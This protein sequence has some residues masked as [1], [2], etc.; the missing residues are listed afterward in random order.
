MAKFLLE[1]TSIKKILKQALNETTEGYVFFENEDEWKK[2]F[3]RNGKIT[4]SYSSLRSDGIVQYF[5]SYGA[6]NNHHIEKAFKT[7]VSTDK[8]ME[9][10]LAN[11]KPELLRT[12]VLEK[13]VDALFLVARWSE[14]IYSV[15]DEKQS[16]LLVVDA[17]ISLDEVLAGLK[18]NIAEFGEI[19]SLVPQLG[20]L[21]RINN[22]E[23][24]NIS[25]TNQEEVMLNYFFSGK[26]IA[27]VLSIMS[28]HNFLLLKSIY[29]LIDKEILLKGTGSPLSED[30]IVRLINNSNVCKERDRAISTDFVLNSLLEVN[31]QA[32][33]EEN[34]CKD[35]VLTF[36]KLHYENPDDPLYA[37][38]FNKAVSCMAIDFYNNKVSPF[39]VIEITGDIRKVNNANMIDNEVFEAFK[40]EGGRTSLKNI[41]KLMHFRNEIDVL[42]SINKFINNGI[43]KEIEP[44]T[45][46]DSVK[47][48][49]REHFEKLFKKEEIN[50]FLETDISSNL[51]PLMLSVVSG[52]NHED[53]SEEL[54]VKELYSR[55]KPTLHGYQMTPIMVASMIGNYEAVEFLL[56]NN[57]NPDLHN[58]NG[59]TA[60]MLAIQNGH[61]AIAFLLMEYRADVNVKNENG[62]S[63]LMIAASKGMPHVVDYMIKK[64]VDVNHLNSIGQSALISALRFNQKDIVVSLIASGT[65]L[66]HRDRDGHSPLYY[67]EDLEMTDLIEKGLWN[68]KWIKFRQNNKKRKIKSH[69]RNILK[70]EKEVV[71]GSLPVF[72]F[73]T[74]L[75]VTSYI[76]VHILFLSEDSFGLSSESKAAMEQLGEEYCS[77]FKSCRQ[78]LPEHVTAHCDQIGYEIMSEYFRYATRCD[79]DKVNECRSCL[80]TMKCDDFYN[81]NGSNLSEYCY[82]C[83]SICKYSS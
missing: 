33:S 72:L 59:V 21:P 20:A 57:A 75:F 73:S 48:G 68:S 71:P 3:F 77:K 11:A 50:S 52:I 63:A 49:K 37:Y 13:I 39:S 82:Q 54:E 74:V 83:I 12:I 38:C 25:I 31:F 7:G 62:Y 15:V 53:V 56:L 18:R 66:T 64:G 46:I 14:C 69:D 70:N 29:H 79:Q 45:F 26:T 27:E 67:A 9:A 19:L 61:D 8:I 35:K 30:E 36:Q 60:L 80:K 78:N 28:P 81:L 65:D 51:T 41:V 5:I 58:G 2:I 6:I 47:T 1:N 10:A 76:N 4:G 40:N 32:V 17:A 23:I 44:A 24:K 43:I 34:K 16:K 42:V 22:N 55:N